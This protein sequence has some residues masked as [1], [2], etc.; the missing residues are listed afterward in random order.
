MKLQCLQ[1]HEQVLICTFFELTAMK[2]HKC[3]CLS[4]L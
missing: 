3:C 4:S 1:P 2:Y